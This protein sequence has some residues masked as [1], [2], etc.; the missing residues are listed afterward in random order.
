MPG[1][2]ART[3]VESAPLPL[4][5]TV[6]FASAHSTPAEY[7]SV[8]RTEFDPSKMNKTEL[9][10]TKTGAFA[11][12]DRPEK[13]TEIAESAT[14]I[15]RSEAAPK[16][17]T[18]PTPTA[19]SAFPLQSAAALARI[20]TPPLLM[21]QLIGVIGRPCFS[22]DSRAGVSLLALGCFERPRM[23]RSSGR[24]LESFLGAGL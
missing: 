10:L 6:M 17:V 11:E 18:E 13:T 7:A 22:E 23:I 5:F 3:F 14:A 21:S 4:P 2:K 1:P 9:P 19:L 20:S 12:T 16:T 15:W 24:S 8:A